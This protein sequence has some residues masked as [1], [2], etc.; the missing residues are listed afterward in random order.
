MRHGW[1]L[2]SLAIAAL[3]STP[4][5]V[6]MASVFFDSHGVWDHLV[7]TVLGRYIRNTV[8]LAVGVVGGTLLLGTG[9]AW[10]VTL[11]RFPGRKFFTWALLLP[12][13]IPT[14]LAAYSYT[15][16]L[17]F[18]GPVQ[19]WLRASFELQRDDYWFPEV[20]SL[21][22]AI[23]LF[24]LVL[25]PYVYLA[26]RAAFL[27]QS[28]CV[29]EVSR[30]LGLSPWRSFFRVALPLARPSLVAGASLVLMETEAEFGAVD[31]C[32]VDTFATGIYRTWMSRGSITAA[33]QLS[34]C[35]LLFVAMAIVLEQFSRR[36]AKHYHP[37]YRY[38]EL[39]SW[40]LRGW[41]AALVIVVCATPVL[42]GFVVPTAVFSWTAWRFGDPRA[43]ELF[44]ELGKNT[45]VLAAVASLLSVLLAMV[46]A[47][48]RRLWPAPLMRAT[49][50]VAGLGYTIPGGVIA[51]GILIPAVWLDHQL[52]DL[53]D[54]LF[55]TTSGLLLTGTVV[56]VILGYQVR[57][58]AVSLNI[59]GAGLTRIRTT[60]DDA[61]RTLG[62]TH[63][64]M[65]VR[66]HAP[67]LRA[68]LL[69]AALLVFVDVIKELP[70]TLILRPFDFDT[71]AVRVYQLASDERLSEA[72]TGAL[73]IILVGLIPVY[74][75]SRA[76]SGARPGA[77]LTEEIRI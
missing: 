21:P 12:L 28:V 57:F 6:V 63:G 18:S 69:A 77:E 45:F 41:R 4:I 38:R 64:R 68:S 75:L 74:L 48:G 40:P 13:A 61:A 30:T 59:L 8:L 24:S 37:T 33:A 10:A 15:D 16:L 7:E 3:I 58:M 22:G 32:A 23:V 36:R 14:Y 44:W 49:A 56:A 1:S 34:A 5:V 27:E 73:A 43:R 46:V 19:T 26:A 47:Y 67:L 62:A 65:L 25:Y 55:E 54:R 60:L 31:Y 11:C 29:L 72:S 42:F 71:L 35:L 53:R 52:A 9:T 76:M 70:A 50:G 2:A 39:P 51:I 20:R 66:I 17:Q